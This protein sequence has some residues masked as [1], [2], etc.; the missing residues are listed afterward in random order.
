[1]ANPTRSDL[2]RWT[3]F[4][5][6]GLREM[7]AWVTDNQDSPYA[8]TVGSIV[9]ATQQQLGVLQSIVKQMAREELRVRRD[10]LQS[11]IDALTADI[12]P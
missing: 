9:V 10:L 3:Q 4:A 2:E 12:G 6:D 7:G 8:A 5:Q 11:Q 1:M